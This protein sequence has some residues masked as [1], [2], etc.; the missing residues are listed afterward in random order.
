MRLI[1]NKPLYSREFGPVRQGDEFD[2]PDDIGREL[3]AMGYARKPDAPRVL[4]STKVIRPE[5]PEVRA[6]DPFRDV[7]VLDE[8]S[9][10]VVAES[11]PMLPRPDVPES[12]VA[13]HRGRRQRHGSGSR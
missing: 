5:A 7:P 4:Y 6:R 8:K 1:A 2:R 11:D 9:S 10:G 12:R 3:L 13:D